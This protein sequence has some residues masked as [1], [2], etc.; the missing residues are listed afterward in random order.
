[1][2]AAASCGPR[3]ARSHAQRRT[4]G[5]RIDRTVKIKRLRWW[6]IALVCCGTI[7][8]YLSRNTLAVLAPTLMAQM[9]FSTREYSYVV[10]AFQLAYTVMQPVCGY[11]LDLLGTRTGF[12]LFAL[13]WSLTELSAWLR[14]WLAV[15]CVLPRWFGLDGS[16]GHSGGNQGDFRMVSGARALGRHGLFQH[17]HLPWGDV[18]A[19]LG[20]IRPASL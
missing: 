7:V 2:R 13:L 5:H 16:R 18:G 20:G 3:T 17:R 10:G 12:A 4:I 15:S 1:M 8:N 14:H 6:I 19:A 9:S 11:V